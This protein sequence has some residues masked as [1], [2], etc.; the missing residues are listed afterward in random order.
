MRQCLREGMETSSMFT[1]RHHWND[2]KLFKVTRVFI[3]KHFDFADPTD[4]ETW[5]LVLLLNPAK[6]IGES[7]KKDQLNMP[8]CSELYHTLG[9]EG[10][11][12]FRD[13]F[14]NNNRA[15]IQK[16]FTNPII[17]QVWKYLQNYLTEDHC[18]KRSRPNDAI[19]MTYIHITR[20]LIE[21]FELIP[22]RWWLEKFNYGRVI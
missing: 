17:R 5:A 10:I 19:H 20:Q 22:P 4:F 3:Q 13:I 8:A 1:G 15:L 12:I 18:F 11:L 6:G 2:Q 9:K 14:S 21:Q 16:F 7:K